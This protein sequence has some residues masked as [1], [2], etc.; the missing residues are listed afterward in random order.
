MTLNK[1]KYY[2]DFLISWNMKRICGSCYPI[3]RSQDSNMKT[4]SI[5]L[6][7]FTGFFFCYSSGFKIDVPNGVVKRSWSVRIWPICPHWHGLVCSQWTHGRIGLGRITVTTRATPQ[8]PTRHFGEC[9]RKRTR[10][11]PA[12]QGSV[13]TGC[14]LRCVDGRRNS[15]PSPGACD[16]DRCQG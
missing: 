10:A 1:I 14:A 4:I 6:L 3:N 2:N 16:R 9:A 12:G 5:N 8:W 7:F 13:P 15:A 11:H